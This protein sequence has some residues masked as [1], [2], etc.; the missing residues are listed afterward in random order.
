M[1]PSSPEL[2]VLVTVE[3]RYAATMV[4]GPLYLAS[5]IIAA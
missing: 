2:T 1:Y 5:L 3:V 4:H